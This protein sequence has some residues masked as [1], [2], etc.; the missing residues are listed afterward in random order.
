MQG[1]AKK[2]N[3]KKNQKKAAPIE[4]ICGYRYE[5]ERSHTKN[6]EVYQDDVLKDDP[7]QHKGISNM[8]S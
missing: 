1:C 4:T 2:I 6:E 3:Q 7:P 5:F 8:L